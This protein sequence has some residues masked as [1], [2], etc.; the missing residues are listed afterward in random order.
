MRSSTQAPPWLGR[1]EWLF[2][3]RGRWLRYALTSCG[4]VALLAAIL[5]GLVSAGSLAHLVS[6][7]DLHIDPAPRWS[8][9]ERQGR[10]T[11]PGAPFELN[12]GPIRCRYWYPA[13]GRRNP[14]EPSVRLALQALV[15]LAPFAVGW[16][17]LQPREW[18]DFAWKLGGMLVLL[19]L[20]LGFACGP[21]GCT[22][23]QPW[24]LL[25]IPFI[26]R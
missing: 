8:L 15:L 5:I 3:C 24:H 20:P 26:G 4:W 9:G 11:A 16:R 1:L 6:A 17:V 13:R 14:A 22:T 7:R 23:I 25:L 12:L 18:G 2:P 10:F 21:M 19:L